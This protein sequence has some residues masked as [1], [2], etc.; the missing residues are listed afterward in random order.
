MAT[1]GIMSKEEL[2]KFIEN[3]IAENHQHYEIIGFSKDGINF[4]PCI[5]TINIINMNSFGGRQLK[6][7]S[8]NTI[9]S[10]NISLTVG[11]E[12]YTFYCDKNGDSYSSYGNTLIE[13][14]IHN[15]RNKVNVKINKR[16]EDEKNI[17]DF[18]INNK[19]MSFLTIVE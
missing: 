2:E 10:H 4:V 1:R 16:I 13:W 7:F 17:F 8:F 3:Q 5:G 14:V 6:E 9:K 11:K 18:T 12:H 15:G 19:D